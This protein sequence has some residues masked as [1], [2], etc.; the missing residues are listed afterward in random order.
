MQPLLCAYTTGSVAKVDSIRINII[1]EKV[2][3][4][5]FWK[6]NVS[7][8]VLNLLGLHFKTFF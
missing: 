6:E 3:L 1:R 5:K 2:C 8:I 4:C 7:S